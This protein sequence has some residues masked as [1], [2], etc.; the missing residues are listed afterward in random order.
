[1]YMLL[2]AVL[3]HYILP[4]R[5]AGLWIPDFP[6]KMAI[7]FLACEYGKPFSPQGDPCS[8]EFKIH[9]FEQGESWVGDIIR[10]GKDGGGKKPG[11]NISNC[12]K[13]LLLFQLG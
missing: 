3:P 7:G 11:T 8:K 10:K 13:S 6:A 1:M 4:S 9:T 12:Y 2:L 5:C